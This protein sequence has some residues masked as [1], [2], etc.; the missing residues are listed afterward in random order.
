[1]GDWKH[2]TEVDFRGGK[3]AIQFDYEG[4]GVIVWCL[5][6]ENTCNG[7]DAT[8]AEQQAVYD[9]LWAYLEDWWAQ[10]PEDDL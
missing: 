5:E 4:D 9:Q 1:M 3:R 2:E 8:A 7:E 10:R 6:G